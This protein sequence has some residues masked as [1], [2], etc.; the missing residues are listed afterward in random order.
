MHATGIRRGIE[1]TIVVDI[2]GNGSTTTTLAVGGSISDQLEVVG[3]RDWIRITLTAGQRYQFALNGSGG[4]PL[5]DPYL[6][7]RDGAG[8]VLAYDD[9]S[10][11][12]TNSLLSF[13]AGSSGTYYLDVGAYDDAG[14]GQYTLTA[15]SVAPP[16]PL[17][18]YTNDEIARYL[19]DGYW[20]ETGGARHAFA[21]TSISYNI[22]G[23]TGDGRTLAVAA[24]DVWRGVGGFTF[25]RTTGTAQIT[26]DDNQSGAYANYSAS[27]SRTVSS[28]VNVG[29]EWL[30][31]YGTTIGSYS[32]QTYIHEIG[33]ALGLGHAGNYNGSAGWASDGTGDNQYLNDS[34]QAT[35]M[36]YFSQDENTYVNASRAYLVGAM[37][38][39]IIAIQ[40]LYGVNSVNAGATTYGFGNT[41]LG[42]FDF[43]RFTEGAMIAFSIY[44][45]GGIDTLNL[46]GF[47]GAQ[48]VD[49]RPGSFS[50]IGGEVGNIGIAGNAV[51]E[52]AVGGRGADDIT[53]NEAANA[54]TGGAGNDI[55]R[56]EGGDDHLYGGA[57]ADIHVGGSGTD[58]ARYDDQVWGGMVI[59]LDAPGFNTGVAAGDSYSGI[60]GIVGGFGSDLISG[61]AGANQLYGHN[62]ADFLYGQEGADRLDGGNGNDHLWGGAGA[63]ILIG[64]DGFDLARYD[65]ADYG[66]LVIRLDLPGLNTGVAAGDTYVG[67]EGIVGGSGSDLVVGDE[68][69][70]QLYGQDGID[71]LYGNGGSDRLDGGNGDDHLWGGAGADSLVGGEGF[72]IARYDDF[73][74]GDLT[75]RLDLPSLNTS[76]AAGDLFFSV[77]G[78]YG[79]AGSDIVVG[80]GGANTLVGL[81]GN[82][83]LF[84]LDGSD[85]L[86][87]GAGADRFYFVTA[88]N[89]ATNVDT[90]TDFEVGID[91]MM[92][93]H[94]VF[95]GLAPGAL[96]A[97][98]FNTGTAATQAD[99]RIIYN[100]ATGALLFDADG[101]GTANTAVQ[102]A[103]LATRPAGLSEA[104]FIVV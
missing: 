44:D 35:V 93:D 102:F 72:D 23:L 20:N 73:T 8:T 83:S 52:N 3:D 86:V 48:R 28:N 6:R 47:G 27:G 17:R 2:P 61:D 33:H 74:W 87:G 82:D 13:T 69:S 81:G 50:D 40:D 57:G 45:S 65:D 79:G 49:L 46:S 78:I 42:Y 64:G 26:F 85:A 55:L 104:D 29:L 95:A 62:D 7:L 24:L 60:E 36:S 38:A 30:A 16:G 90:I 14:R 22:E 98:A 97:G 89:A 58:F 56:G 54:L 99:D 91:D 25:T 41:A 92:L 101:S 43:S 94:S 15:A 31:S 39:D 1:G 34:W 100:L 80:D 103:I 19:T 96:A 11:P 71:F 51:I 59:R 37:M 10:G 5:A 70:N 12:G 21:S 77:E 88:L 63:D 53:G 68:G 76:A 4:S 32:F 67:I 9:D 66:N 18:A 84:G 75:V